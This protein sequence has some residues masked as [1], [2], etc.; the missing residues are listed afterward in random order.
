LKLVNAYPTAR[1]LARARAKTVSQIPYVTPERA[2]ALITAAK[3]SVASLEDAATESLL[4]EM[5][6]QLLH[7]DD[8]I[9]AQKEALTHQ[10]DL[11]EEVELLKSFGS[12][13]DYA[14]VGL[15][16]EIQ[17][18][19]RFASAKKMAAFFGVH[20]SYK[21]SGDGIGAMRMSKQGS[22]RMRALL[23]MIT[24]NAMQHNAIIAPLYE[25]LTEQ[26][27]AK[28]D[29]IGVCMHK[30]LRILYGLL[31]NRTRFDAGVDR[32]NQART[33]SPRAGVHVA[34]KRRFQAFDRSAPISARA[35]KR[36]RQQQHSQRAVG[37]ACGMSPS[38]VAS[39]KQRRADSKSLVKEQEKPT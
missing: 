6:R 3:R 28:M 7:L 17:S 32:D 11:P 14:A 10:I 30:T 38:T 37:T 2:E 35:Q 29:A 24:L 12:I 27:K 18:V 4:R 20:P 5:A 23:L 15:L 9:K 33:R 34:R 21:I 8:L 16:L 39:P 19:E 31:K 36:R 25:R 26:G 22:S 1:R 13:S